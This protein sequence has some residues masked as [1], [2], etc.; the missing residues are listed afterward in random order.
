MV[1]EV[2]EADCLWVEEED[3]A[4]EAVAAWSSAVSFNILNIGVLVDVLVDVVTAVPTARLLADLDDVAVCCAVVL[5][6]FFVVVV[7]IAVAVAVFVFVE[8]VEEVV[9]ACVVISSYSVH[10]AA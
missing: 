4:C 1:V 2:D 6:C 7:A 9:V 8:G 3:P 5:D 10:D